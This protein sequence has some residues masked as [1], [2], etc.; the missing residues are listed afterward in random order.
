MPH[1]R[2][3]WYAAATPEQKKRHVA[4]IQQRRLS[5]PDLRRNRDKFTRL[6][7]WLRRAG[8]SMEEYLQRKAKGCTICGGR[9]KRTELAFDHCHVT[10][11]VRGL[12]CVRCNSMLG[13]YERHKA[14]ADEYLASAPLPL[15][16]TQLKIAS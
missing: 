11:V 2:K 16:Q 10:G 1:H 13:W 4:H 15:N 12:L 14:A 3:G 6:C 9:N 5:A 7:N 8:W